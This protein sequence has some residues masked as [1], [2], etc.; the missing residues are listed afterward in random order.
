MTTELLQQALDALEYRGYGSKA[1]TL[2]KQSAIA[3]LRQALA[4][5][6]PVP[7]VAAVMEPFPELNIGNYT[8]DDVS[9]LN[10]WGIRASAAITA[11]VQDRDEWADSTRTANTRFQ[12]AESKLA[13]SKERIAELEQGQDAFTQVGMF[14]SK[15]KN[16]RCIWW[17]GIDQPEGTPIYVRAAMGTQPA[18]TSGELEPVGPDNS[19]MIAAP[20]V[21][22]ASHRHH[23]QCTRYNN[24]CG[25][26]HPSNCP[27]CPFRKGA[28]P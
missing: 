8:D 24:N 26:V 17:D 1:R 13:E 25:A 5:P 3:A 7:D 21:V 22:D 2:K 23:T 18:P 19:K 11:L 9:T 14:T 6:V 20:A 10:E 27:E 12:Q 4:H 28:Q 16:S 15:L